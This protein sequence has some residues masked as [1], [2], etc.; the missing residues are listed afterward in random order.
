MSIKWKIGFLSLLL[1]GAPLAV[2]LI[3]AGQYKALLRDNA[4]TRLDAA[5]SNL[6]HRMELVHRLNRERLAGITSRTHLRLSLLDYLESGNPAARR[7]LQPILDDALR[8]I[9]TFRRITLTD[10]D[11]RPVVSTADD[12]A[13]AFIPAIDR[14]AADPY[15]RSIL[16]QGRGGQWQLVMT[17]PL[18]LDDRVIGVAVLEAGISDILS[19]ARTDAYLERSGDVLLTH[20]GR[21]GN[22]RLLN[23]PVSAPADTRRVTG[24]VNVRPV[25]Y[26]ARGREDIFTGLR[27][28]RDVPVLAA[29]RYDENLQL[30][31]VVKIDQA[32]VFGPLWKLQWKQ[33]TVT[34]LALIPLLGLAVWIARSIYGPL[35]RLRAGADVIGRGNWDYRI[36]IR[37]RDEVGQLA[38]AFDTMVANLQALNR[39][40]VTAN[41]DL[42]H[43]TRLAAHDLREPLRQTRSLVDL[44][45]AAAE[46]RQTGTM[47][48]LAGRLRGTSDRMLAMIDDFRVLTKIGHKATVREPVDLAALIESVLVPHQ[49]ALQA[50]DARVRIYPHPP[51]MALYAS[52][53]RLLYDNLVRNA[54]AHTESDGF[55]LDFTAEQH[56]DGPWVF[57]VRNTHSHIAENDLPHVF[58]MFR[59]GG[60]GEGAGVGLSICKKVVDRHQGYIWA[61]SGGDETLIR[62]TLQGG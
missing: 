40:V 12:S 32:E 21:D 5:A 56:D 34:L 39:R 9:P 20:A 19:V 53:V 58:K 62:F 49:A 23:T 14:S 6:K 15:K 2:G 26:A 7:R 27:D 37:R 50:R 46:K 38:T 33:L 11:G 3:F 22:I 52:L 59:A 25:A 29:T 42:E 10:P 43:F 4:L 41:E 30:G 55:E 8:S 45:V 18:V 60:A 31:M 13:D 17:G 16:R 61:E 47:V 28:Y 57:G 48:E 51:E 24:G 36:G 1:V 35:A 54:L 44:F